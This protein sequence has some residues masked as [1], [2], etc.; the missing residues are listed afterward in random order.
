[1]SKITKIIEFLKREKGYYD[2]W[3]SIEPKTIKD[4]LEADKIVNKK[5]I[6][7]LLDKG[8]GWDNLVAL[9]TNR[10]K[11]IEDYTDGEVVCNTEEEVDDFLNKHK[12]LYIDYTILKE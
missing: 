9:G 5:K 3:S 1:M 4:I 7:Y 12:Y 8:L 6:F 10:M 2:N 11:C